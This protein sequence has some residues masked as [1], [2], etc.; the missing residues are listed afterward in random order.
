MPAY[1]AAAARLFDDAI[2]PSAVGYA[3]D[4]SDPAVT[5]RALRERTRLADAVVRAHVV[6]VSSNV[7]V[8]GAGGAGWR[9]E[10]H[11][12]ERL[13]GATPADADV[14][15]DVRRS[16]PAA[17][18]LVSAEGR[19]AGIVLIAFVRQFAPSGAGD[20]AVHFHLTGDTKETVAA[21]RSAA[22]LEDLQ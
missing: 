19:L 3:L 5:R 10:L 21:V 18:L 9:L 14:E 2:E 8:T 13:A 15:L 12:I 7:G 4:P 20:R 17:G 22:L 1:D 11:P 6:T 16:D